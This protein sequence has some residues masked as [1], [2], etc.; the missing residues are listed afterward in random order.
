M[1]E[2]SVINPSWVVFQS[3]LA[4]LLF[5]Q[6]VQNV[7]VLL[8]VLSLQRMVAHHPLRQHILEQ[9][10]FGW[11]ARL[12]I[13][14]ELINNGW[15][16]GWLA[17]LLSSWRKFVGVLQI[18]VYRVLNCLGLGILHGS[19]EIIFLFNSRL[20]VVESNWSEWTFVNWVLSHWTYYHTSH[21][22]RCLLRLLS[23]FWGSSKFRVVK[24]LCRSFIVLWLWSRSLSWRRRTFSVVL[25]QIA[26][27]SWV[28]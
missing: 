4:E 1:L 16:I 7:N 10:L 6:L 15:S 9:R 2:S 19:F 12:L 3:A 22:F 21:R 25:C 20:E 14:L 5:V 23:T 8:S 27:A 26:C 13:G 11:V 18:G 28:R 17:Q 24:Q